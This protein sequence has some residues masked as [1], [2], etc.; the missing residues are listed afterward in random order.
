MFHLAMFSLTNDIVQKY[1]KKC[2]TSVDFWD[3]FVHLT[4]DKQAKRVNVFFL[5]YNDQL[6]NC[7]YM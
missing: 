2:I 3:T 7:T 5:R 6:G 4:I 1:M